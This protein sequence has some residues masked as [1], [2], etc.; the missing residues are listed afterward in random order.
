MS[1]NQRTKVKRRLNPAVY[2]MLTGLIFIIIGVMWLGVVDLLIDIEG[3]GLGDV[4]Y[5][6][7]YAGYAVIGLG[8]VMIFVNLIRM[9]VSKP[10]V[11]ETVVV[12]KKGQD[13]KT[14]Q[15]VS[16]FEKK[17]IKGLIFDLDGTLL[18][19]LEDLANA[20]NFVLKAKGFKTANLETYRLGLGN[21]LR[22]L[23]KS[24]LPPETQEQVIDDVTREMIQYY[25][26]HSMVKTRPFEGVNDMLIQLS[27]RG[28]LMAVVS[29]KKDDLTKTLVKHYFPNVLFVDCIGEGSTYPRKPDPTIIKYLSDRM[30]LPMNQMALVGDSEVDFQTAKNANMISFGVMW[31]YR[32]PKELVG[33]EPN[34][35]IQTPNELVMNLDMM[36]QQE[37]Y[38]DSL[39]LT[40]ELSALNVNE[41]E[42]VQ[43]HDL[44]DTD[45]YD[46]VVEV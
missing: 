30:M 17:Y 14:I 8:I 21:G 19:T 7:P 15:E 1:V 32:S 42:T 33:N 44:F 3:F 18:N 46:E 10:V 43:E 40:Q 22:N 34:T 2:S 6:L 4:I 29:N 12:K 5:L 24:V 13:P 20:G 23:M 38:D 36:N 45:E 9:V 26:E 27:K 41:L 16:K 35:F 11:K 25:S 39:E 31:G 28:Y 37:S